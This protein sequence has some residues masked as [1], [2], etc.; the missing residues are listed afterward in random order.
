MPGSGRGAFRRR[1]NAYVTSIWY[2]G[3]VPRATLEVPYGGLR[4]PWLLSFACRSQ[5]WKDCHI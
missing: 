5:S 2:T 3:A 4:S 1:C